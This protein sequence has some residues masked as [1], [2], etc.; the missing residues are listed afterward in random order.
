MSAFGC[1]CGCDVLFCRYV[2]RM[3]D[4]SAVEIAVDV[5]CR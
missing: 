2:A 1:R 4:A 5:M 3:D